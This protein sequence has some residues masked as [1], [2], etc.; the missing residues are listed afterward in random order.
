MKYQSG[1]FGRKNRYFT[2]YSF[3]L[4]KKGKVEQEVLVKVAK[5][6]NIPVDAITGIGEG[7]S[8]NIVNAYDNSGSINY[9][10][11]F[12]PIDKIV[13]LYDNLLQSEKEKV[14]ILEE[15]LKGKR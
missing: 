5:A 2:G 6:L 13:E 3:G 15:V 7:A 9:T 12:N 1:C 11:T 8:I 4:R 10:P 14:A